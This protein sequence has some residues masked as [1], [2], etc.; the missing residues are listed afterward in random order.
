LDNVIT[1]L[2]RDLAQREFI[3]EPNNIKSSFAKR[4]VW[5]TEMLNLVGVVLA[6]QLK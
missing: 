3:I 4:F 2:V 5:G 1:K 6:E